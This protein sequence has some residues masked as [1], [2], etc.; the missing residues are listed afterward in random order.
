MEM[1]VAQRRSKGKSKVP[2]KEED[3]K[4]QFEPSRKGFLVYI[5]SDSLNI[6]IGAS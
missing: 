6:K 3:S 5:I 1:K 2:K 4:V